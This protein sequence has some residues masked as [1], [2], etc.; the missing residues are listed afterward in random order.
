MRYLGIAL[1]LLV[2]P[3]LAVFPQESIARLLGTV[4]DPTGAVIT[5]AN[6]VARNLSTGLERKAVGNESSRLYDP[7]V[8]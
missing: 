8:P 6:V 1:V 2:L 7:P 3:E 4:N 5:G